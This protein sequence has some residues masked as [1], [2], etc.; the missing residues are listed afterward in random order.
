MCFE[1][2][3]DELL[4]IFNTLLG[5]LVHFLLGTVLHVLLEE[6]LLGSYLCLDSLLVWLLLIL[7]LLRVMW[8]RMCVVRFTGL[9]VLDRDGKE[10]D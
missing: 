2:F 8:S 9:V 1:A 4:R 6:P 3:L 10:F 7:G 5:L